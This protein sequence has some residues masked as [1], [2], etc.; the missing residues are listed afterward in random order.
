MLSTAVPFGFTNFTFVNG[1]VVEATKRHEVGRFRF[2][3]VRPMLDVMCIDATRVR[4]AGTVYAYSIRAGQIARIAKMRF[5][6]VR[7]S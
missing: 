5:F 1:V 2:A 4:A 3:A 7:S 6:V